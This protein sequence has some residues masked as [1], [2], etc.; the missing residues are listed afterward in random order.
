LIGK[1]K[2]RFCIVGIFEATSGFEVFEDHK[3]N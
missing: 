1:L 2:S 3:I